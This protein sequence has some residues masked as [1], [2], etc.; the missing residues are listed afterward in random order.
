MCKE[1]VVTGSAG[2]IGSHVCDELRRRGYVVRDFDI[3]T[4][5]QQDVRDP[6]AVMDAL[7]G[8]D[9]VLHLAAEPYIP[10]C[11]QNPKLFFETNANGTLNVLMAAK[12]FGIGRVIYWSTSEVYGTAQRNPMDESHPLNPHSTYAVSKLAADRLCLT[13]YKEHS[14]PVVILRQ[15]NCYGPRETQPYVIPEII[16]QL[17]IGPNLTLGNVDAERD[18]TYVEDAARAAVDLMEC[19]EAIGEVVNIGTG[20]CWRIED[21]ATQLG[22]TMGYDEVSIRTDVARLRPF[23][24]DRLVCDSAKL[25]RLIGWKPS[26]GL[27]AGLQKT[28]DWFRGNGGKWDFRRNRERPGQAG[29]R[30]QLREAAPDRIQAGDGYG[31]GD[32]GAREGVRDG[33]PR[34]P[35]LELLRIGEKNE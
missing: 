2:F 16:K 25:R 33:E 5:P 20:V 12:R 24:V 1:V 22:K 18:F 9:A 3:W 4:N 21:I 31:S 10:Y 28:A 17:A 7:N 29:L 19:E 8:A 34:E 27:E 23:D 14:V 15:F 13:F 30:G 6:W 35:L 32:R 11:Y 26:I